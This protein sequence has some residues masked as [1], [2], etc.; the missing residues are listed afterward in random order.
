MADIKTEKQKVQEITEKLEQGIKEL[1]ESEKYKSYLNTMSKFHQYSFNNTMLIA[2]QKPDAT[3]VAGYKAWQKNFERHVKKG[4]KGIRILAPS[5][6]KIKEEQEKIDPITQELMLD[7]NGKPVMEEVEITIPSFRVVPVFDVSQ[8]EGRELPD[9]EVNELSGSVED[10]EIFMQALTGVSSVPID[11][12][13]I[14]GEARGYFD[15]AAHRIAIQE[16]MSESQTVKTAIH[17][18]AHAK[19]HDREQSQEIGEIMA[20]DRSTKEVEAESIAYT[21]CQHFGIDTS[22]Y[23]FGYIAGWSSGKD[24]KELKSSLDTIRRAASE[25]ITDIEGKLQELQKDRVTDQEQ[26]IVLLLSN[27]DYSEYSLLNVRGMEY[28]ELYNRLSE[29]N[30][31]DRSSIEAYLERKGAWVTPLA[32][33]ETE[34]VK[35]Y[36]IDYMY[37]T[38]TYE[39]TDRKVMEEMEKKSLEPLKDTDVVIKISSE[40]GENYEIDKITN[41]P[42]EEVR[43]MLNQVAAL[44]ENKR[45]GNIQEYLKEKGA[46]LAPIISSRGLNK[47]GVQ[48]YDFQLDMD[49]GKV[50]DSTVLSPIKQAENLI[51]RMEHGITRFTGEERDFIVNY[52]YK[53]DDMEKTKALAEGI[54][55]QTEKKEHIMAEAQAEIDTLPDGLIGLSQMHEYGYVWEE[56]LPLTKERA[57]ELFAQELVVYEL[58]KDG[59]ETQIENMEEFQKQEGMF[60]VE[61]RD[62]NTYLEHQGIKQ[63][64]ETGLDEENNILQESDFLQGKE[65]RF[66]IYQL[67][68]NEETRD[69]QFMNMDFLEGKGITAAKENYELVYIAPLEEDMSLEDIYTQFNIDRP[70]DFKGHSL[71]VSDVVVL[72]QN[73]EN[74]SHYVDSFGYRELPEFIREEPDREN[75]VFFVNEKEWHNISDLDFNQ[76][77][78]AIDDPYQDNDFRLLH[79]Q[80]RIKDITPAGVHYDTYE[81]AAKALYKVEREMENLPFNKE[82]NIDSYM[83][84]GRSELEHILSARELQKQ[85]DMDK[86]SYYVIEDLSTWAERGTEKSKLERFDSLPEAMEKF[87]EYQKKD[88]GDKEDSARATFGFRVNGMEFDVIHVR[89]KENCLSLDFTHSKAAQESR[90]FMEDLQVLSDK[91]GFDKV[92]VHRE[93]TPEE[94]KDFVKQRFEHQLKQGGMND[95]SLYM[96][97]FHV[98]YEHGKMDH[99]LPTANQRHIIEDIPFAEWEN[100]YIDVNVNQGNEEIDEKEAAVMVQEKPNKE[101]SVTKKQ[102]EKEKIVTLTVAECGEFHDFGEYHKNIKS[103]DKAIAAYKKIPP[104]RMNGIPSIGI[105][106]HTE[107]TEDYEDIQMDIF[108]SGIIDLEILDYVPDIT[109]NPK[110]MEIIA[111]LVEKILD[112]EVY[113]SLEKWQSK[114][115]QNTETSK[116]ADEAARLA[117]EIDRFSHEY[118]TVQYNEMVEDRQAQVETIASD[119]RSGNTEYLQNFLN[120]A[121]SEEVRLG[122]TDIFGQGTEIED[123]KAVQTAR[124]A[125]ELSDRLAEYKPLA[126]I[127]EFEE[128]NY[129]MIDNVLNNGAEKKEERLKSRISVKEKLTEKKAVIEKKDKN[130]S[131]DK[132]NN[133]SHQDR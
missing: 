25:L 130:L 60:G 131:Q 70:T 5:P 118:D 127:E 69:I 48:F 121:I 77:Y 66:G 45:N 37:N 73:G 13:E 58:H 76:N 74:T 59:S 123:S 1:F 82:N 75:Q 12:E 98:L 108:S 6:Y 115:E 88:A 116:E 24:I 19:L 52:N 65:N 96:D 32:D 102:E 78:F 109:G 91:I 97:R 34:E 107:G 36:H 50:T 85:M 22:D 106:I 128:S 20:K 126:K 7:K 28:A 35:E 132:G 99:L 120:A 43:E 44:G 21:V 3:L 30:D 56:M 104:E 84:N 49:N 2:M 39:I 119:I 26:N 105:K 38:D 11:Y 46:E 53:F 71:S 29:M 79:L 40:Q 33:E 81:E 41:M 114:E 61:K 110:A 83:V 63:E 4:E 18:M 47:G 64:K 93:M 125:K 51:N 67:K 122:I 17:E 95:M 92:R 68:D 31:E 8:T 80:N 101:K 89:N 94:V 57:K 90:Q 100:P 10:Y 87:S 72:H 27:T 117:E 62:W 42:P 14:E 86:V 55:Y 124:Q 111:E 9:M 112:A 54:A 129:N 23:S 133:I 113:G 16:G 15:K 103:V